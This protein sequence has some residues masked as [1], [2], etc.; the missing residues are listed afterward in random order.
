MNG[1]VT[2]KC[3]VSTSNIQVS[4]QTAENVT[5]PETTRVDGQ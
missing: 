1:S 4:E 5:S 3:G 2:H